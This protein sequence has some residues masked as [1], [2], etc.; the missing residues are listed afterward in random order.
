MITYKEIFNCIISHIAFVKNIQ[1]LFD[2]PIACSSLISFS[3][4]DNEF[5][6]E[7]SIGVDDEIGRKTYVEKKMEIPTQSDPFSPISN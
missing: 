3:S 4:E 2:R 5:S 7:T 6:I 1:C